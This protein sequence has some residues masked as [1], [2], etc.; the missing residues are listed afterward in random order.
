MKVPEKKIEGGCELSVRAYQKLKVKTTKYLKGCRFFKINNNNGVNL[1]IDVSS[2]QDGFIYF[3]AVE[4]R[5][6]W[7]IDLRQFGVVFHGTHLMIYHLEDLEDYF[8]FF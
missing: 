8:V 5:G 1:L 3:A 2:D 6:S 7:T 4:K